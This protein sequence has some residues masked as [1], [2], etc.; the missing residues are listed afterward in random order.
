MAKGGGAGKV[1]FVL[2]LAVVLELLIIIV[3]RDEAEEQLRAKTKQAMKIVESILS[4]LQSGAGTEA[5]NT[6]PQDEIT[7]APPGVD[8]KK[9]LGIEIK[10]YRQYIVEV[11]VT[12]VTSSIPKRELETEK[13]YVQR[14]KKLVD[15]ANVEQLQYQIFYTEDKPSDLGAPP[16]FSDTFMKKNYPELLNV[17][18]NSKISGEI[19]GVEWK[20]LA[21]KEMNLDKDATFNKINLSKVSMDQFN[22]VY[23]VN[24]R[25]STGE[26][27]VPTTLKIPADS[28]F[29]YSEPESTR[30]NAS[31]AGLQKRSFMVYFQ[32]PAT[33]GWYKLRFA[34]KTNRILGVKGGQKLEE[35]SDDATV[36]IGTVSLT[37]NDLRKVKK[38]LERKLEKFNLPTIEDLDKSGDVLSFNNKLNASKQLAAS[39]EK[40]NDLVGNINLYGYIIKLLAPGQ[41]INFDQ[42]R[43]NIEFNVHVLT[44][45]P[46]VSI[47]EIASLPESIYSFDKVP[48]VFEFVI[49]PYQANQ[50]AV[51]GKVLDASNNIVARVD[52]QPLDVLLAGKVTAPATGGQRQYR[53][54]VD[55]ALPPGK[56]K[57]EIKH[58]LSIKEKI[59]ET[60]LE[61]F[62]TGLAPEF[63]KTVDTKFSNRA[64]YGAQLVFAVQSSAGNKIKPNQF[65]IYLKTN[66]NNQVAPIEGL[67]INRENNFYF[68]PDMTDVSCRIVWVQPYT[69]NEVDIYPEQSFKVKQ[70]EPSISTNNMQV[71]CSGTSTKVKVKVTGLSVSSVMASKD[72]AAIV[73]LLANG[74]VTKT[75]GLSTYEVSTEPSIEGSEGVYSIEFELTGKPERGKTKITGSVE[76]PLKAFATNPIN[77]V[78]SEPS[79]NSIPVSISFEPDRGGPRRNTTAPPR[80]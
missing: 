43:G 31:S 24:L 51:E 15:L 30:L 32:P 77:K 20:L 40:A 14:L 68:N 78:V 3:E 67:S 80:R 44:P 26:A 56:Y 22:P 11:G 39:D 37:V 34:S 35:V 10:P 76:I 69:N 45:K 8:I 2:Y 52:M 1:Y 79:V 46:L 29:F 71:V 17:Q 6:R 63:V 50:N 18:P 57:I 48:T 36:N 4:Q 42:N 75:E 21:V 74:A 7:I 60:D 5:I 64:Y 59:A 49:A 28:M 12:D 62:K 23:P 73:N 54:T 13:E 61:I 72:K 58:K 65:K 16:F 41:S 25:K 38:E 47:P 70:E 53:A 19:P 33:A 27:L 9:D 66:A 55:K